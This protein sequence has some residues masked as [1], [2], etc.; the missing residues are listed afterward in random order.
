VPINSILWLPLWLINLPVRR[1]LKWPPTP[2]S[3]GGLSLHFD[4]TKQ[5]MHSLLFCTPTAG[6]SLS[7]LFSFISCAQLKSS[8]LPNYSTGIASS[9]LSLY[10]SFLHIWRLLSCP[11]FILLFP[12]CA[13]QILWTYSQSVLTDSLIIVLFF[14]G[15]SINCFLFQEGLFLNG[16]FISGNDFSGQMEENTSPLPCVWQSYNNCP[17]I[18]MSVQCVNADFPHCFPNL[19]IKKCLSV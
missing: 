18:T 10:N 12:I 6:D 9:L 14:S 15:L 7:S 3:E 5:S 19:C 17:I 4:Q 13:N 8:F 11:T 1:D 2:S 16:H